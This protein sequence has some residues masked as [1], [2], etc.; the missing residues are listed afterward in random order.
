M[1]TFILDPSR[2]HRTQPSLA[3]AKAIAKSPVAD[4]QSGCCGPNS[5]AQQ[6]EQPQQV[7]SGCCA[8]TAPK[9]PAE[10]PEVAS[11][12]CGPAFDSE[13]TK[14]PQDTASPELPI[15]IIGAGPVGLA[16]AAQLIERGLTPM[17]FEA[18]PEVAAS[19]RDFAH[20]R[21]FTPWTYLIDKAG[22]RLLEADGAWRAPQDETQV[23]FAGD[24][25]RSYLEPLAALPTM[26]SQ[27][28]LNHRVISI[29]RSGHDRM[30][31]GNRHSRPFVIVAE[32]EAG[33]KRYLA[34]AVIDASGTWATPNPI[35]AGG[36]PAD[37]E[38]RNAAKIRH[39]MPDILGK[40][41]SRY[42]GKRVLIVGSGHSSVGNVLN[43]AALAAEAPGTQIAWAIRRQNPQKLWG[44]GDADQLAHRGALGTKVHNAVSS[45]AVSLLPGV[46]I[47]AFEATP[48]GLLVR[49]VTGEAI[50]V[51]DEVIAATGARPDLNMLRE[52]RLEFDL[53]TEAGKTLGPLIDPNHHSCGSVP[54]HGVEEL[55][56]PEP[57]FYIAG[58]KSYGRAPTFL[59][60]TGYEQV[61]SIAA[62]LAGDAEAARAVFLDLPQTGVCSTNLAFA[63]P[64]AP[65]PAPC[66]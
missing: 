40:E 61:R 8:P 31:D 47:G 26:A 5:Q 34:R 49:D 46:S 54:P 63:E 38:E 44:G 10:P 48:E 14:L 41:R 16:A 21:L 52:L 23:P 2:I 18:A 3:V 30:K 29:S 65:A 66:C 39:G 11:G 6:P 22:R 35:G 57:D 60:V 9:P 20:V 33:P 27:L 42:A 37:G 19:F 28:R 45:G 25:L 24:V 58:M 55:R 1:S 56:H 59:L 13:T 36:V 4:D 62:E 50:A 51:V 43:A 64:S 12:C 17:V 32:T 7:A 15:A 53:A